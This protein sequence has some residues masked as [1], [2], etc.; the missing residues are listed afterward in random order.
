MSNIASAETPMVWQAPQKDSMALARSGL[1]GLLGIAPLLILIHSICVQG[2]PPESLASMIIFLIILCAL[3]ITLYTFIG[4]ETTRTSRQNGKYRAPKGKPILSPGDSPASSAVREQETQLPCQAWWQHVFSLLVKEPGLFIWNQLTASPFPFEAFPLTY[5]YSQSGTIS[6]SFDIINDLIEMNYAIPNKDDFNQHYKLTIVSI[7]DIPLLSELPPGWGITVSGGRIRSAH[8]HGSSINSQPLS[9]TPEDDFKRTAFTFTVKRHSRTLSQPKN[10]NQKQTQPDEIDS[11]DIVITSDGIT[12]ASAAPQQPARQGPGWKRFLKKWYLFSKEVVDLLLLVRVQTAIVVTTFFV[13]QSSQVK[14]VLL[15]M[16]LEPSL[17][18][19][20]FFWAGIVG[21]ALSFL[22]WLTSR[23]LIRIA[24]LIDRRRK[25][26]ST[27]SLTRGGIFSHESELALF[28]FAWISLALF[29]T[30]IAKEA[31]DVPGQNWLLYLIRPYLL[32]VLGAV[33]MW[34]W[35]QFG[36]PISTL[37]P[38][39]KRTFLLLFCA[40]L[41]APILF[42][43]LGSAQAIPGLLGSIAILFWGLTLFLIIASTIFQFSIF[44][45]FPLLFILVVVSLLYSTTRLNDNHSIRLN[46]PR[47][48]PSTDTPAVEQSAPELAL[49]NRHLPSLE[50]TFTHWLMQRK[51]TI[52]QYTK[53]DPY[54][55]YVV[56]AQGGGIYAAYHSAKALAVLSEEV[57]TFNNHLFAISGVS[58]GS[59]GATIY[60]NA[61]R[62]QPNDNAEKH[63]LSARID[64]YFDEKND[65]LSLILAA[66]LFGDATQTLFPVPVAAWDR[67]LGLELAFENG[68]AP[69][70][71][72]PIRLNDSFYQTQDPDLHPRYT[73]PASPQTAVGIAAPY[74][75]LNATEVTNGRRHIL[76]PFRIPECTTIKTPTSKTKPEQQTCIKLTDADFHEPWLQRPIQMKP[77]DIR[78]STAAGLS[79]RFSVISPYGFF[80]EA[81]YRRFID[82]GFYDNSGAVTAKE[83]VLGMDITLFK[84]RQGTFSDLRPK[85]SKDWEDLA[86]R[87]RVYPIAIVDQQAVNLDSSYADAEV[88]AKAKPLPVPKWPTF[89]VL[90]STREARLQ[91]AVD[92]LLRDPQAILQSLAGSGD[93][94]EP[95]R[96]ELRKQFRLAG[97]PETIYTIPLGWKLS[98]QARS[99]INDQIQPLPANPAKTSPSSPLP[100]NSDGQIYSMLACE[101]RALQSFAMKRDPVRTKVPIPDQLG[102]TDR[103]TGE[104]SLSRPFW[105]LIQQLREEIALPKKATAT[106]TAS[107]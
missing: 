44:Q 69:D 3:L 60:A 13:F 25:M 45:D 59:V 62:T 91:K 11:S 88:L 14:D 18:S 103:V 80:P 31:F 36:S 73:L 97:R 58:G 63:R 12:E 6:Q 86:E 64:H 70:T 47:P 24:P 94:S 77:L 104:A 79:A 41:A 90:F 100:W 33:L 76:S 56:S 105:A 92:L 84:L 61:E 4:R 39:F 1:P 99:F 72:N 65:R 19:G 107:P 81:R 85:D 42:S 51:D 89:E 50:T 34:L 106:A 57:P 49:P 74:L 26:K 21:M 32:F 40:G 20:H 15:A 83:I 66:M 52:S 95:R 55:V 5:R 35:R 48:N 9:F 7:N 75:V 78:F 17:V 93:T 43:W 102:A 87:V 22:L 10:Q 54:P 37:T 27:I 96:V 98:C 29:S 71:D 68:R 8:N 16:I 53:D 28:W 46:P 30:P 38:R 23:Q 101:Q 2:G 82:G 67:S